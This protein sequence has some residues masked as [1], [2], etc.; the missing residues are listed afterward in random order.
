MDIEERKEKLLKKEINISDLDS[1]E[2][3]TIKSSLKVDL[4]S[5]REELKQINKKIREMKTKIDNWAD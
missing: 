2:V 3:E 4:A 5:K 1:Q